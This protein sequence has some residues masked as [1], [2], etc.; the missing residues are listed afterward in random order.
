VTRAAVT[1]PYLCGPR[2]RISRS[3]ISAAKEILFAPVHE[4]LKIMRSPSPAF[5]T[6]DGSE[7]GTLS[8]PLL[9]LTVRVF[10]CTVIGNAEVDN[11]ASNNAT[12]ATHPM[13]R[14]RVPSDL[15]NPAPSP[16]DTP[17]PRV[18][19]EEGACVNLFPA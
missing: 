19:K 17:S 6:S 16:R 18:S 8:L 1:V 3:Y 7:F 12:L 4:T 14:M 11:N 15:T 9:F 13:E 2:W 5:S 10:A